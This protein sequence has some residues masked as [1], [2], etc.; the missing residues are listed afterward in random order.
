MD[1]IIVLSKTWKTLASHEAFFFILTKREYNCTHGS[2][3]LEYKRMAFLSNIDSP[4]RLM[5][6]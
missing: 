6:R 4:V 1:L 5:V 2:V 3:E